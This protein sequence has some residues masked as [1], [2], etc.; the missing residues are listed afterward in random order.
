MGERN[1]QG[2]GNVRACFLGFNDRP[3]AKGPV[4]VPSDWVAP[5]R[6]YHREGNVDAPYGRFSFLTIRER[7]TALQP[8]LLR[9]PNR[10]GWLKPH[11]A[12]EETGWPR[13]EDSITS[14]EWAGVR[15]GPRRRARSSDENNHSPLP[16]STAKSH[17]G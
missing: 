4:A 14:A 16:G 9:R 2:R 12:R 17:H 1:H 11:D 13:S 10:A 6:Y 7:R 3:S 5:C 8:R 15:P